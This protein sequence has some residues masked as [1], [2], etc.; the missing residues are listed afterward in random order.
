MH[1]PDGER[2]GASDAQGRFRGSR[3]GSSERRDAEREGE[4]GDSGCDEQSSTHPAAIIARWGSAETSTQPGRLVI[5]TKV[6]SLL[7]HSLR[8]AT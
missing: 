3:G 6:L 1:A 4:C 5:W 2:R 7:P 8:S